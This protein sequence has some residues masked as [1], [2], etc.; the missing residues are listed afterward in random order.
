MRDSKDEMIVGYS[1]D[2]LGIPCHNPLLLK[3]SLTIR[4]VSVVAGTGMY[5]QMTTFLTIADVIAKTTG[6]AVQIPLQL[7]AYSAIS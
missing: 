3:R 4:T 6:L 1:F 7:N 2:Q 5:L